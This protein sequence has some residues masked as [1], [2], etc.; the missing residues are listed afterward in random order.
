M[1]AFLK[2][3]SPQSGW[4]ECGVALVLLSQKCGKKQYRLFRQLV[5]PCPPSPSM[6]STVVDKDGTGDLVSG[7]PGMLWDAEVGW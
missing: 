1:L 2:V 3:H 6:L 4:V 5:P 7:N